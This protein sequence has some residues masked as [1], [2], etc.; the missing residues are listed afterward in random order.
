MGRTRQL[1]AGDDSATVDE[2]KK[3]LEELNK[4][5]L[6][7]IAVQNKENTDE[8]GDD[9]FDNVKIGSDE[10]IKVMSLY[11]SLLNLTTQPFGKGK[12]FSFN[13][14]GVV[15]RIVY[16]ELVDIMDNHYN[17]LEKGYFVILDKRVVRKHGLDDI[18]TNILS[19][20]NIDKIILGE[21]QTDAVN[22]FKSA[23]EKQQDVICR[24]LIDK[25]VSG[26]EI[27]LNLLDRLSREVGYNIY[28]R[29]EEIMALKNLDNNAK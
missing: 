6:Q 17:F 2:L 29:S 15:K 20:A 4:K 3:Q 24:L 26:E 5:L 22:L 23:N 11:S 16:H 28:E 25:R 21:N 19:K 1:P 13:G 18:Y 10:Y 9:D 14:F 7:V 8:S 27:D 12:V